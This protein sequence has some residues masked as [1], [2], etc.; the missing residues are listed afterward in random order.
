[1]AFKHDTHSTA[2]FTVDA[3]EMADEWEASPVSEADVQ[4]TAEIVMAIAADDV[5]A[6]EEAAEQLPALSVSLFGITVLL[7]DG[8]G[9]QPVSLLRLAQTLNSRNALAYIL[10]EGLAAGDAECVAAVLEAGYD[11]GPVALNSTR[12]KMH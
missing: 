6:L 1:M 8:P 3:F 7:T 5:Y 4:V 10:C 9:A 2:G 11:D 12:M